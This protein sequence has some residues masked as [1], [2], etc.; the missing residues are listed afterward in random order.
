MIFVHETADRYIVLG[1]QRD[2]WGR[3]YARATVGTSVL[4]ELAKAF[5]EMVENGK[6]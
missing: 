1:A 6:E 5:H 4:T 3:G 2:A